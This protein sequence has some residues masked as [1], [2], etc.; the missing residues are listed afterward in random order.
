MCKTGRL[1]FQ[2]SYTGISRTFFFGLTLFLVLA[3]RAAEVTLAWDP[4]VEADLAGYRLHYGSISGVY[5]QSFD[6]GSGTT[7]LI[8]D[9]NEGSTYYFAVTAYNN[10]GLESDF[11]NEV[12]HTASSE[13]VEPN[14]P[15]VADAGSY[16]TDE[17]V[18]VSI[19]LAAQDPDGDALIYELVNSPSGGSLSGT[20]PN[21]TY[22][23]VEGFAGLDSFSFRVFDGE[24]YSS[25]TVVEIEVIA[26]V[27]EPD[28]EVIIGEPVTLAW[29][30]NTEPDISGYK[31]YFGIESGNYTD[32][33]DVGNITTATIDSLIEGM[34]YYFAVTA[35][36]EAGLE[37]DYSNEVVFGVPISNKPPFAE[38]LS[39]ELPEDG[40]TAVTLV[41]G[42]PEGDVLTYSILVE[43]AHGLLSGTAPNLV[44]TPFANYFGTDEFS[45]SV[46]DGEYTSSSSTVSI[47]ITP[48]NDAPVAANLVLT[49]PEDSSLELLLAGVDVDGDA[50]TFV[51]VSAPSH[52]AISGEAPVLH[53]VPAADFSGSDSF[54]YFVTDGELESALTTV[55]ITVSAVDDSPMANAASVAT[56]EDTAVQ[57]SIEGSDADGD[58]LEFSIVDQ[59]GHGTLSGAAPNMIYTPDENYSGPDSFSFI[60]SDGNGS[61]EPASIQITVTS[62]NDAPTAASS[63]VET[64]EDTPMAVS[65][66]GSDPENDDLTYSIIALPAHGELSGTAP[67]FVYTPELN[68]NGVD[69]FVFTVSDGETE[70]E[71]ATTEITVSPLNDAP[72]AD[73]IS[74]T[75]REDSQVAISIA[76][77]DPDGDTLDYAVV[78][79]PV[80]GVLSGVAP[81]WIYTPLADYF[82]P[83]T[84][85]FQAND[86]VT[87]S[88]PIIVSITITSVN[89]A[90]VA[91]DDTLQ[92]NEDAEVDIQLA[93]SDA[94]NDPLT[95]SIVTSPAHGELSGTPPQLSY[96]P[97]ANHYGTDEF[98]YLVSDGTS[99]SE[100]ATIL[101]SVLPINDAPVA[102]AGSTVTGEDTPI[103][104]ALAASD[105]EDDTLS[106]SIVTQPSHGVVTGTPPGIIYS[107]HEN[108]NGSDEFSFLV[109]DGE[110]SSEATVVTLQIEP[111]NDSPT[112]TSVSV[113]V[114][115]DESFELTLT[116][117]DVDGDSLSYALL[118]QPEHGTLSG[119]VPNL[120]Y[121]P[122]KDFVG[123]DLF[124]YEV[125][126][127]QLK[128]KIAIVTI[129]VT[130]V[131]D[132][133][134][135]QNATVMTEEDTP[136]SL[137]L[138]GEDSDGDPLEFEIVEEPLRGRLY[139]AGSVGAASTER[140]TQK[141]GK[142]TLIQNGVFRLIYEPD[143]D[144]DGEDHFVFRAMDGNNVSQNARISISV[145]A[146]NDPP[147]TSPDH[148]ELYSG[149]EHHIP[150]S[151]LLA[152][153]SD[154]DGDE[155]S[156]I[157]AIAASNPGQPLLIE[158]GILSYECGDDG[159]VDDSIIYVVTD[160]T[161][162]TEG[163]VS[164]SFIS[165]ELSV[166]LATGGTITM[167]FEV[168]PGDHYE[169]LRSTDLKTWLP[170][171]SGNAA[172]GLL[173]YQENTGV[174]G[175]IGYFRLVTSSPES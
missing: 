128:S 70:S 135:V 51:L 76:A 141:I 15:P 26:T 28:I 151:S 50:L 57:I 162:Q 3:G 32:S 68:F 20:F 145:M 14:G 104:I 79:Q 124:T 105:L 39:V 87:N 112:S 83:D 121:Q 117:A 62:V 134:V 54:Q 97:N 140:S 138:S 80:F 143:P 53:Y 158:N 101:I 73:S 116:G 55:S 164:L 139:L 16:S 30:A 103:A 24:L 95:Y 132:P 72:A 31:V 40:S 152:N 125:S 48:R 126:D 47:E 21:L 33:I 49:L 12:V 98:S 2:S 111:V 35:Y 23:P 78:V 99:E 110:L 6:V 85:A 59:P 144:F 42:D 122:S 108:Y 168:K 148:L 118:S 114:P 89:D 1:H 22:A 44:Y 82:G 91:S 36:N 9:L 4:N 172:S 174:D 93:S 155:L 169:V 147:E 38:N 17:G 63:S 161:E 56:P 154:S 133:P 11:S 74:V 77:T 84:F 113:S 45:F 86:S 160:G 123:E 43:P 58:S 175:A 127:G 25:A 66:S 173:E 75:T 64:E 171:T 120:T 150:A 67:E 13:S 69:E 107:P 167:R 34:T 52:G 29:D 146:V 46:D 96:T 102:A 5:S 153:D 106:Y 166:D 159:C 131:N 90:P 163:T 129:T 41:A 8:E 170:V 100:P 149:A 137:E 130:P 10:D 157:S 18:A 71:P 119:D 27:E 136:V 142:N 88:A 156:I 94:E 60:A 165:R 19:A 115:E 109:F 61:S 37:S 7:G 92:T 81:D 65:L